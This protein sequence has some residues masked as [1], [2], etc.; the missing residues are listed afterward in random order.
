MG[1][2]KVAGIQFDIY[3]QRKKPN[4]KF[5]GDVK[6]SSTWTDILRGKAPRRLME[7]DITTDTP[8]ELELDSG[9]VIQ[10]KESP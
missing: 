6:V 10:F 9:Q 4:G 2:A 7:L 5:F 8:K 3:P 1:E